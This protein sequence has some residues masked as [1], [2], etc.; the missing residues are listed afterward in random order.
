MVPGEVWSP[1]GP[2]LHKMTG[3]EVHGRGRGGN[4]EEFVDGAGW[5]T[6]IPIARIAST[7]TSRTSRAV[8]NDRELVNRSVRS[9]EKEQQRSVI[10]E[11]ISIESRSILEFRKLC[12]QF[13]GHL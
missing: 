8:L 1:G 3:V 12:D 11:D 7:Y 5:R 10:K 4:K 13:A 2:L 9:S 6:P